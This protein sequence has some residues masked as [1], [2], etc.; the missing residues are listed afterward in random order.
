MGVELTRYCMPGYPGWIL[1]A[2]TV[3]VARG[4]TVNVTD[5]VAPSRDRQRAWDT[6]IAWAMDTLGLTLK[7]DQAPGWHLASW[8]SG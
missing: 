5:L 2:R 4:N 7:D 1:S 8:W 6:K 3:T